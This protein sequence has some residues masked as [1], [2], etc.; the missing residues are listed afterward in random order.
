KSD[1]ASA[2]KSNSST[3]KSDSAEKTEAGASRSD[4][5]RWMKDADSKLVS[6]RKKEARAMYAK[7]VEN[8]PKNQFGKSDMAYVK[9]VSLIVDRDSDLL[10]RE[11]YSKIKQF[12]TRYP[13]SDHKDYYTLI[14]AIL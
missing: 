13:D 1:S 4:I 12:E 11:A 14:R 7:V 9:M 8:D 3:A 6:D 10:R 2:K 5:D